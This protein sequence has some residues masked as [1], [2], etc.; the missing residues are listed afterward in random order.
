MEALTSDVSGVQIRSPVLSGAYRILAEQG[1]GDARTKADE[2][3]FAVNGPASESDLTRIS[4]EE[5]TRQIGRDDVRILGPAE[6]IDLL[7]GARRGQGLWQWC[8]VTLLC[9]LIAEMLLLSWPAVGRK[10]PA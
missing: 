6:A 5:L 10:E 3:V 4:A 9:G 2:W 8:L 1:T 7:G